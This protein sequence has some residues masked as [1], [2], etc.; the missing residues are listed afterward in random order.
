[1]QPRKHDAYEDHEEEKNRLFVQR[2]EKVFFA[3][4]VDLRAFV[5]AFVL[6]VVV[7]FVFKRLL[8]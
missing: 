3:A 7:A 2:E 1:M 6:S 5:V 4:F 8:S